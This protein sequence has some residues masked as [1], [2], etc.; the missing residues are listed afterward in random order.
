MQWIMK[1]E[2]LGRNAGRAHD[3]E[4]YEMLCFKLDSRSGEDLEKILDEFLMSR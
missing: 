1:N 4:M 2:C 3:G